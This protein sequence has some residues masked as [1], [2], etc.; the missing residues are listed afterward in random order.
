MRIITLFI[1][2][3]ALSGYAALAAAAKEPADPQEK[4]HS[5]TDRAGKEVSA[6]KDARVVRT[7]SGSSSI[8][9]SEIMGRR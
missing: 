9:V 4:G 1:A 7:R 6:K 5:I 2:L 8:T 3:L